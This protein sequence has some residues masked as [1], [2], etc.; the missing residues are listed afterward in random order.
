MKTNE[1]EAEIFAPKPPDKPTVELAFQGIPLTCDVDP[2]GPHDTPIV[3]DQEHYGKCYR[4]KDGEAYT[5]RLGIHSHPDGIGAISKDSAAACIIPTESGTQLHIMAIFSIA[6]LQPAM[7]MDCVFLSA[8]TPFH[9]EYVYRS[10]ML[11]RNNGSKGLVLSD[12]AVR[13]ENKLVV[14]SHYGLE[15]EIPAYCTYTYDFIT[16]QVRV[17]FDEKHPTDE[18]NDN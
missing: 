8:D 14:I 10:A 12:D 15:G 17:V 5:I 11:E 13:L 3:F 1:T 6:E 4:V 9:L 2:D 18:E 7:F 16:V